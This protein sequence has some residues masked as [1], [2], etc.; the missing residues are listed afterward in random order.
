MNFAEIGRR[1]FLAR[2]SRTLVG[3]AAAGV[4][5]ACDADGRRRHRHKPPAADPEEIS[6]FL[7]GTRILGPK[8]P[9]AIE[10]LRVGDSVMTSSGIQRVRWI[11]HSLHHRQGDDW[12]VALR[13]V[14]IRRSALAHNLPDADLLV[15][16]QHSLFLDGVLIPA[17]QLINGTTIV[18]DANS[19][20]TSLQLF[21]IEL[22]R[23]E[24]ILAN[25]LPVETFL[26]SR[27]RAHF[28]NAAEYIQLYG[29]D[30]R[31]TEQYAPV[32]RYGRRRDRALAAARRWLSRCGL[33]LR[34]QV[35]RAHDRIASRA[36]L[37]G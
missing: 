14:R 33:D 27:G 32:L 11:G 20:A 2:A 36:P 37:L 13:P 1:Q 10:T 16:R 35:M 7:P 3:G 15:S 22:D 34:D 12:P 26:A 5:A 25:G 4:L 18:E 6:C 30:D 31:P 23:H 24:V 19:Q 9:V 29:R 21:N 17:G 8:G 28:A